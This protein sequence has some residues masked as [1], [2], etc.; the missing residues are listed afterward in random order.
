MSNDVTGL[1]DTAR[2]LHRHR[3]LYCL[4]ISRF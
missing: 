2:E 3:D 4:Q 1:E